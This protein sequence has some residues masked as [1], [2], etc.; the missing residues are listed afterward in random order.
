MKERVPYFLLLAKHRY[1]ATQRFSD[2][3]RKLS[4]PYDI[5]NYKDIKISSYNNALTI[6]INGKNINEYSHIIRKNVENTQELH[7]RYLLSQYCE[8]HQIKFINS[9]FLLN[10]MPY[11]NKLSQLVVLTE[12]KVP[13]LPSIYITE[14]K[15]D[16]IVNPFDYPVIL[17]GHTGRIGKQVFLIKN[18]IEMKN[19]LR[20]NKAKR[21][22]IL[23]K[24]S[25]LKED[26]RLI[27]VGGKVI[28]GWKRKAIET[29]KTTTGKNE[30]MLYNNPTQKEKAI[31]EK[32]SR[33]LN[34]DYCA[35]DMMYLENK[36]YVLE[37]NLNA[38][39]KVYEEK[40]NAKVNVAK[41]I[42]EY[43]INELIDKR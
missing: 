21:I 2:E 32:V 17:K 19:F 34:A 29:F 13:Y 23:Q 22:Y 37:V 1:N 5:A 38:G 6:E 40:L 31:A 27:L 35:V 15:Y 24:F 11:Y 3:L 16:K 26:F 7:L 30:K 36:P 12:N 43:M 25:P 41:A 10:M 9:K 18:Q 14:G 42:I 39:F 8:A 20:D 28:G 33:L 4:I